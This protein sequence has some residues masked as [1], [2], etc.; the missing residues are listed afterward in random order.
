MVKPD[1]DMVVAGGGVAGL[2][3]K[4]ACAQVGYKVVCV[5]PKMPVVT[6]V[7]GA[8]YRT[9][10]LLQP[11]VEMLKQIG[12]WDALVESACALRDMRIIDIG[13]QDYEIRYDASFNGAEIGIEVFGQNVL[14]WQ[15]S[16]ELLRLIEAQ[17]NAVFL[18]HNMV[19]RSHVQSEYIDVQLNN[20][21]VRAKLLIGADGRSSPT[22]D[23]AGIAVK[24][25]RYGQR[26]LSFIVGHE[27]P[28]ESCSVELHR[29]GGPCTFVPL[30]SQEG[31]HISSVVWMMDAAQA[32]Q[33]AK[34]PESQFLSA[35]DTRSAGLFGQLSLRSPIGAWPIISQQ[36]QRLTG[37][38]FVL[39]A[40]AAHVVPPIGAQG[41]N[42]SIADIAALLDSL[43]SHDTGSIAQLDCYERE[44]Q[45]E[46]TKRI[47]GIDFLNRASQTDIALLKDL[48]VRGL[49]A[50]HH[51]KPLRQRIMREGM[52]LA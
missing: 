47:Y 32:A 42:M 33:V 36:A 49:S 44:R 28:H 11:A 2:I 7:T 45:G 41:L 6:D 18:S 15:L 22:R 21:T 40:E 30:P 25:W 34:L 20:R 17:E 1:V 29:S 5:D 46:I 31:M 8:D 50:L 3:A 12:V 26:A 51:I 4:L 16:A 52:G 13:G 37:A 24:T 43:R 27:H 39:I 19:Q 10:A 35:L 48:R 9:T 14:N 23:A 38:R